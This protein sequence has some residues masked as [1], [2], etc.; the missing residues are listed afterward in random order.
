M[1][2]VHITHGIHATQPPVLNSK[3]LEELYGFALDEIVE[4][5]HEPN[6]VLINDTGFDK[7]TYGLSFLPRLF[8]DSV[9]ESSSSTEDSASFRIS[10]DDFSCDSTEK[11]Q[12]NLHNETRVEVLDGSPDAKQAIS[13]LGKCKNLTDVFNF[14]REVEAGLAK[15]FDEVSVTY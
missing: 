3:E 1:D 7:N 11:S 4:C 14:H 5:D 6:E 15:L 12:E 9:E 8:F 2:E 10:A 13:G